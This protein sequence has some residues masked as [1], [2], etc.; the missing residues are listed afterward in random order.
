MKLIIDNK[1]ENAEIECF[2]DFE[3]YMRSDLSVDVKFSSMALSAM[4]LTNVMQT[5]SGCDCSFVICVE[6]NRR[7]GFLIDGIEFTQKLISINGTYDVYMRGENF[8][9]I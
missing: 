8:R 1:V 5:F 7:S 2:G 4:D 3:V 9:W 6:T